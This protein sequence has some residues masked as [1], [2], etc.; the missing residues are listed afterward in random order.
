LPIEPGLED[1]VGSAIFDAL[2]DSVGHWDAMSFW[3]VRSNSTLHHLLFASG[4]R[5]LKEVKIVSSMLGLAPILRLDGGWEDFLKKRSKKFRKNYRRH[6]E[7]CEEAGIGVVK[8]S[9]MKSHDDVMDRL[10]SV[11]S[12][13]WQGKKG[14]SDIKENKRFFERII[15][16][17]LESAEADIVWAYKDGTPLS[18]ALSLIGNNR[19]FGYIM[20][21]DASFRDLSL[22]NVAIYHAMGNACDKG[23]KVYDLLTDRNESWK[24][25]W[26]DDHEITLKHALIKKSLRGRLIGSAL[27][28]L[29]RWD[30]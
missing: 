2:L 4:S 3:G 25:H 9:E 15:P 11:E 29:K 13:S 5:L 8:E 17:L 21:Y 27:C 23:I 10:L 7:E 19:A 14:R 16:K 18:F 30:W 24:K 12:R 20:G 28:L 6:L 1:V 22:G 26:T